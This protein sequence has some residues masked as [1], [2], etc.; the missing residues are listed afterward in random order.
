M[1]HLIPAICE[2][3]EFRGRPCQRLQPAIARKEARP[4]GLWTTRLA[5]QIVSLSPFEQGFRALATTLRR[6]DLP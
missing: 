6:A 1:D 3:L 5:H 4:E 2:K